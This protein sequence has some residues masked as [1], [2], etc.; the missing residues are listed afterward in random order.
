MNERSKELLSA[1]LDGEL[2]DAEVAEL[3]ALWSAHP[4]LSD[5]GHRYRYAG[6]CLRGQAELDDLDAD[7]SLVAKLRRNLD[8]E[9]ELTLPPT[10]AADQPA[11][12]VVLPLH[13]KFVK[14]LAAMA[15]AAGVAAVAIAGLRF[16]NSGGDSD[17]L[18]LQLATSSA[19]QMSGE[20]ARATRQ[21]PQL[22]QRLNAYLVNH[23]EV[24]G[25][26][27]FPPYV[28]MVSDRSIVRR[29]P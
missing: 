4:E 27:T 25:R 23:S 22:E 28:R 2:T 26:G 11:S 6:E 16:V 21:Q 24:A 8:N 18:P 20:R 1:H 12:A 9:P 15:L 5:V 3:A 13:R 7:A 14:P 19:Q 17:A 29:A 10:G